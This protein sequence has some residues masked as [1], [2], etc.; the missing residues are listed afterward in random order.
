MKAGWSVVQLG[1]LD[2]VLK[3]GVHT[4]I[5]GEAKNGEEA[6]EATKL[7]LPDVV[8]MDVNMPRINGIEATKI[9]TN[10]HPTVKVIGLSV[11]EDKQIEKMLLEAGAAKYVTKSSVASQLVDAIRQVVNQPS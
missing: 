9:L 11:H 1:T 7:V 2:A 10:E 6:L 4:I 5:L 3:G 8:V